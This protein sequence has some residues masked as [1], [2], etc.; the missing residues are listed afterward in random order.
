MKNPLK[1]LSRSGN[2]EWR[3]EIER[4]AAEEIRAAGSQRPTEASAEAWTPPTQQAPAATPGVE[5]QRNPGTEAP[6]EPG[7]RLTAQQRVAARQASTS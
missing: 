5:R 6:A 7:R 3:E 4:Q 2:N 1:K